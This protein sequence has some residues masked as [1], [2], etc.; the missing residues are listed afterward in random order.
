MQKSWIIALVLTCS[1][2]LFGQIKTGT[3]IPGDNGRFQIVAGPNSAP[4]LIDTRTGKVWREIIYTNV[5]KQPTI[6]QPMDRVDN[7]QERLAWL[8]A[9]PTPTESEASK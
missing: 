2:L 3:S 7:E 1:V 4:L 8:A 5:P 6:W 9:H